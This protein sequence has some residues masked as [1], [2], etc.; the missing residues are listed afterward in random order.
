MQWWE[1]SQFSFFPAGL[2][3]GEV[4]LTRHGE[5]LELLFHICLLHVREGTRWLPTPARRPD[6]LF[7][8]LEVVRSLPSHLGR[9]TP[10]AFVG[11]KLS[12]HHL[13]LSDWVSSE[14]SCL[15]FFRGLS[16]AT[17]EG[18]KNFWKLQPP[19]SCPWTPRRMGPSW[20]PL[21][22]EAQGVPLCQRP[23]VPSG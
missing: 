2:V 1:S 14:S 23:G 11:S 13:S 15:Y 16:G 5:Q 18:G 10:A 22:G 7:W 9:R 17:S 6:F 4:C 20:C 19:L 8:S 21:K 12:R 3:V